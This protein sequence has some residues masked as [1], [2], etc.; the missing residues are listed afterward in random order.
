[1][2]FTKQGN[3]LY[4][5]HQYEQICIEPWGKDALRLRATKSMAFTE[6]NWA[7]TEPLSSNG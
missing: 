3:A 6:N 1:M 7:L 4:I 5:K 2:V